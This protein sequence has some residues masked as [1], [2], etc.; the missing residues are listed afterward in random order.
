MPRFICGAT[1]HPT[2]LQARNLTLVAKVCT[3]AVCVA[4]T[5]SSLIDM[6]CC[7][8]SRPS[9]RLLAYAQMSY[10]PL[11]MHAC[12]ATCMQVV[13]NLANMSEFGQKE[14]FMNPCNA[15][16]MKNRRQMMDYLDRISVST[17][18]PPQNTHHTHKSCTPHRSP[19]TCP[20]PC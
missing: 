20:H 15:F 2:E 10:Q 4:V 19:W 13:Q 5:F 6:A 8:C 7:A 14:L 11:R 12:W 18:P 1:D 17:P 3:E 16:I 9:F